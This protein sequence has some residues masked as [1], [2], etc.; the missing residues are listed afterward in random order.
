VGRKKS[1]PFAARNGPATTMKKIAI[2]G[3]GSW[4]T[5]L[6]IVLGQSTRAHHISLWVHSTDVAQTLL[7]RR[8]N[9]I[10]LPGFT[11]PKEIEISQHFAAAV[12][13]ADYVLGVM[14]SAHAAGVYG[15][16][17]AHLRPEIPIISATK[18]I[19]TGK[20]LR[21]SEVIRETVGAR[22]SPQVAVL[23]GPSFA[24][25]V[26]HDDPTALVIASEDCALAA[27][28]QEELSGPSLRLYTNNDVAGVEFGGAFKNVIALTAGVA[29][30]LGLGHSSQ[31]ALITRG[32]AEMGRLGVRLGAQAETFVGLA[33]LGD[34]VLTCTGELSR[35]RAVGVELGR[36]RK[37]GEILAATRMVAEGVGTTS[38]VWT[39]ARR[40]AIS[41]PITEQIYA[42]LYEDRPPR[43]AMRELMSRPLKNE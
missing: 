32:L 7:A 14:P 23:S 12:D 40:L 29:Q 35:N 39:L 16:L 8:V 20:L 38:A 17:L 43:D 33:G 41:M 34:L 18:G 21:M 36:G 30:G 2:I 13:G 10:Y 37:L 5:A 6:A 11:L 4:G 28:I 19:E 31:A 24:R 1:S 26:A 25:E 15:G 9:E 3:A 27:Q 42:V 22:F